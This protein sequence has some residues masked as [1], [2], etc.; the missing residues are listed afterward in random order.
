MEDA[1]E[2]EST[3][4]STGSTSGAGNNDSNFKTSAKRGRASQEGTGASLEEGNRRRRSLVSTS[5][6]SAAGD[7][8]AV[9]NVTS[10]ALSLPTSRRVAAEAAPVPLHTL[11]ASVPSRSTTGPTS[12]PLQYLTVPLNN[13]SQGTSAVPSFLTLPHLQVLGPLSNFGI[14]SI[15]PFPA[16]PNAPAAS[17]AAASN[18]YNLLAAANLFPTAFQNPTWPSE[19]AGLYPAQNLHGEGVASA[20]APTSL[21]ADNRFGQTAPNPIRAD[22][23]NSGMAGLPLSVHPPALLVHQGQN[24]F[25]QSTP[26]A[27]SL[28]GIFP[29]MASSSFH[30][31]PLASGVASEV[32]QSET[33]EQDVSPSGQMEVLHRSGLTNLTGTDAQMPIQASGTNI[34]Q[35]SGYAGHAQHSPAFLADRQ[36]ADDALRSLVFSLLSQTG[37]AIPNLPEM[38][39]Q[40]QAQQSGLAHTLSSLLNVGN[41]ATTTSLPGAT[42]V[43]LGRPNVSIMQNQN[44]SPNQ[45]PA[46]A[47]TNE[48]RM[49]PPAFSQAY[50]EASM[51]GNYQLR[52]PVATAHD[53]QRPELIASADP[54]TAIIAREI[55]ANNEVAAM[56]QPDDGESS[57]SSESRAEKPAA[58]KKASDDDGDSSSSSDRSYIS[59]ANSRT[60]GSTGTYNRAEHESDAPTSAPL[61]LDGTANGMNSSRYPDLPVT[62]SNAFLDRNA[63][64]AARG[65]TGMRPCQQTT[66]SEGGGQLNSIL[67]PSILTAARM[68]QREDG[69]ATSNTAQSVPPA[70]GALIAEQRGEASVGHSHPWMHGN[71]GDT[72]RSF[73]LCTDSEEDLKRVS[74]F[75]HLARQQIEVFEATKKE[76]ATSMQGRN[77]PV[78][79]GQVGIRCRHCADVP[80]SSRKAGCMYYP[81]K[82]RTYYLE[83]F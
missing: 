27:P 47:I 35:L 46:A 58:A 64:D 80:R 79:P 6:H 17:P 60:S 65:L 16:V 13:N 12:G 23:R 48:V 37:A 40:D 4:S 73:P 74:A 44:Y 68:D 41:G 81:W 29:L 76:A 33:R 15:I 83:T 66:N 51:P 25:G 77:N 10:P 8:P 26:F 55:N 61:D 9:S 71:A 3:S 72:Q 45:D 82:V 11:S 42:G 21:P 34:P 18:P 36:A 30:L 39:R 19:F 54:A 38:S 69:T 49:H 52:L 28:G 22:G 59:T 7:A 62:F 56:N 57:S 5:L 78:F 50:H 24:L 1:E 2:E 67:D 14:T 53:A 75:Q 20:R 43:P 63:I 32:H 70:S 31:G